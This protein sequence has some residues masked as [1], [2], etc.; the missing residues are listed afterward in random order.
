ML[1]CLTANGLTNRERDVLTL[2]AYCDGTGGAFPSRR[3]LARALGLPNRTTV[4]QV[5]RRL[6]KKQR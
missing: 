3:Q 4:S 1:A 6:E 2:L 5:T